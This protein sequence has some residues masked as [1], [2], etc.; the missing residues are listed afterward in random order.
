MQAHTGPARQ[1]SLLTQ[2]AIA[3]F[4]LLAVFGITGN[5]TNYSE[6][7]VL[8]AFLPIAVAISATAPFVICVLFICVTYF[9]LHEAYPFLEDFRIPLATGLLAI[10]GL[11][12]HAVVVRSIKLVWTRELKLFLLLCAIITFGMIFSTDRWNSYAKWTDVWLKIT[13]MTFAIA[14]LIKSPRDFQWAV[15]LFMLSALLVGLVV[16]YNKVHGLGLVEGTRV[17]IQNETLTNTGNDPIRSINV[18]GDPNDLALILLFPF[19]YALAFTLSPRTGLN[20]F[21]GIITAPALLMAIVFTQSRGG[22]IGVL[23]TGAAILRK[24]VR[25]RILLI[26]IGACAAIGLAMAMGLSERSSGGFKDYQDGGLDESSMS[27]IH[28]WRAAI[29]MAVSRPLTGVGLSNYVPNYWFHTP[30]WLGHNKTAHSAWFEA[31]AEIGFPGVIV[32]VLLIYGALRTSFLNHKVL[33]ANRAPRTL[34]ATAEAT[35][36]ALVGLCAAGTFLSIAFNWPFY[37]IIALTASMQIYIA[38]NITP[39]TPVQSSVNQT[40]HAS[41][42]V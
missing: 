31:L 30:E 26:A 25:S 3:F 37:I 14:W 39:S 36:A 4:A 7:M 9:R 38:N 5:A 15:S 1:D 40:K 42:T 21:L 34:V 12:W 6:N 28:A 2:A 16:I 18:L 23:C 35:F 8:I 27:R 22:L 10:S 24:Y 17:T 13:V 29:S 32:L 20:R 19:A 41:A 11:V 33:I